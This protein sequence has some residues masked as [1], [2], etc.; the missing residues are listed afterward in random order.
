MGRGRNCSCVGRMAAR[1]EEAPSR[2]ALRGVLRDIVKPA[3]DGE[4]LAYWA[5][6]NR[7]RT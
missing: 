4:T 6:I 5:A 3:L 1:A 7:S 2:D